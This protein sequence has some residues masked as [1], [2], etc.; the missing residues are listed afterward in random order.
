V[1]EADRIQVSQNERDGCL[2]AT[3][4]GR[5][6]ALSYGALRDSLV[7]LALEEPRALVVEVDDLL[8][9]SESALTVFSSASMRVNEWPDVPIFLVTGDPVQ[10]AMLDAST[11][12]RFVPV[13]GT[14]GHA[15]DSAAAG[16]P[17]RRKI[18]VYPPVLMCSGAARNL[19]REAC[20]EWDVES[21]TQDAVC[22]VSELVENAVAHARTELEV[23]LELRR[24]MLTVA[25][26]DGSPRHAV[27]RQDTKGRPAGYGLQIISDLA[28]SWGCSPDLRGGKVVWAVLTA[29]PRWFEK[30]PAWPGPPARQ[31]AP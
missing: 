25:V 2:V 15:I 24:G 28:R 29:G 9:G 21:W 19:V 20:R 26:R 12:S 13:F 22:V 23:R 14:V 5:L 11:M 27:L 4:T 8:V 6:D 17:R 18:A 3:L 31:G 10:R 7:K 1:K 16:P 30:F